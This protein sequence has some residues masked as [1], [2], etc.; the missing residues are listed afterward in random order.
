VIRPAGAPGAKNV[1][2]INA[3]APHVFSHYTYLTFHM[4]DGDYRYKVVHQPD[5]YADY[6]VATHPD[7]VEAF[8]GDDTTPVTDEVYDAGA[9]R[10][11]WFYGLE[12]V[13]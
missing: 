9:T 7:Q 10:V 8:E 5:K 11:D 1:P 13:K 6:S 12:L 2:T 3:P 4:V